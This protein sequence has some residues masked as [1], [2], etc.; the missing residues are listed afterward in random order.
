MA[1]LLSPEYVPGPTQDQANDYL[2][3]LRESGTTNMFGG[4]LYLMDEFD[5]GR[6]QAREL[7]SS[8][9]ETYSER[10]PQI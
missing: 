7:L 5:I 3:N 10:H 8:W 9:M 1:H 2:D 4:A 6:G